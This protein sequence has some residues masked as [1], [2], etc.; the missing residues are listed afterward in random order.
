M[1]LSRLSRM[2]RVALLLCCV[3]SPM[4]ANAQGS[5][6]VEVRL[7]AAAAQP[8]ASGRLLVF[9][10]PA[11]QAL[12]AAKDGKVEAVNA[13]AM[14]PEAVTLAAMEVP[15]LAAGASVVLDA[16]AIAF[17]QPFSRLPKGDYYL[18]AVLDGNRDYAYGGRGEGD[19]VSEPTR[20]RLGNARRNPSLALTRVLPARPDPWAVADDAPADAREAMAATRAQAE[21]L[22]FVSP[23]LSAFWGRDI[24]MRGWVLLPPGYADA[25]NEQT[26]YPTAYFT[27]GFGGNLPGLVRSVANVAEAMRAGSMP[28]MIWVFLDESSATGTHEFADSVN[29]GPW[30]HALASELIPSLEAR[31]RMDGKASGRLLNG[32]SSGGWATLWLQVTYPKLFGGTWSTAPD[33]SDF[34]DFTGPDLYAPDANVYRRPDGSAW[35]LVRVDGKVVST[36]EQYARQEAVKGEVGGQLASFD[37]VFSPRGADGRPMPM[38]DRATGKVDPA[39]VAYWR[40]HYD[41]AHRLQAQWPALKPDLDGKIRVIVGDADTFYLDGAAR[42]LKAVLDGLGAKADFRF[43]PGKTHSDLY[44]EGDDRRALL[45]KI[46]WEMHAVA[47]PGSAP[48]AVTAAAK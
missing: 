21:L 18:Q 7:D 4:L 14:T 13:S 38:F 39:V 32:H 35:P 10:M 29:N 42:R 40:E 3:S 47:R 41:I 11:D 27:H 26:R 22:D 5:R 19:L 30:G 43:L 31:Y 25:A 33:S 44:V 46:A 34:H 48:P 2:A 23:A 15:Y 8:H 24:H 36:F 45:K 9:A 17:P 28:P 12:A 1:S 20:V 37:W 6:H 16:D